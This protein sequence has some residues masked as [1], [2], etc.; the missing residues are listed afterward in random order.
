MVFL[1]L[2]LVAAPR[3]ASAQHQP[4]GDEPADSETH[5]H[6]PGV[7]YDS[8]HPAEGEEGQSCSGHGQCH[9]SSEAM[10]QRLGRVTYYCVCDD[11]FYGSG[12]AEEVGTLESAEHG[13]EAELGGARFG[14]VHTPTPLAPQVLHDGVCAAGCGRGPFQRGFT[15]QQTVL[16]GEMR[17]VR[18][19]RLDEHVVGDAFQLASECRGRLC[20]ATRDGGVEV[21]VPTEDPAPCDGALAAAGQS[22]DDVLITPFQ[23]PGTPPCAPVP[24]QPAGWPPALAWPSVSAARRGAAAHHSS[25]ASR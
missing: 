11:G 18:F 3:L 9:V 8:T 23:C 22:R 1:F 4:P 13:G 6:C 25:P 24:E 2:L 19:E 7:L 16:L 5:D 10:R 20:E 17:C 14:W 21:G 15:F 12:C